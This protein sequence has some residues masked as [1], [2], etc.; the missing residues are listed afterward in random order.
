MLE[1]LLQ[2]LQLLHINKI[3]DLGCYTSRYCGCYSSRSIS[4][5]SRRISN[6]SGECSATVAKSPSGKS[7]INQ[8][9]AE[10]VETVA[11]VATAEGR[12][13]PAI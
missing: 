4:K 3:N 11:T 7:V 2:S 10:T 9:F 5:A 1:A 8:R 12:H 13:V 6:C